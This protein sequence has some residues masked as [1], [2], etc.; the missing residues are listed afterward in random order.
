VCLRWCACLFAHHQAGTGLSPLACLR[1]TPVRGDAVGTASPDPR[2][3]P[4]HSSRKRPQGLGGAEGKLQQQVKAR[5][6]P[7]AAAVIWG[8]RRASPNPCVKCC[9]AA[10]TCL[11]RLRVATRAPSNQGCA[12]FVN[13]TRCQIPSD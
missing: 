2:V 3:L 11:A 5:K 6:A 10:L 4:V 1:G 13:R 12:S 9:C 7:P 8:G